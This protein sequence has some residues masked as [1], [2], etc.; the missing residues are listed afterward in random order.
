MSDQ[1]APKTKKRPWLTYA[2]WAIWALVLFFIIQNA[3]ASNLELEDRATV[4]F[5]VSAAVWF[6]AGI[7]IWFT[8]RG[9]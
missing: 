1:V 3:M 7:V 2:L 6:L 8:R 9:R 5:W 4:I